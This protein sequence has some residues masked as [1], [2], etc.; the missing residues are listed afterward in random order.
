MKP[1][2]PRFPAVGQVTARANPTATAASTAFPPAR[3]IS[4]PASDARCS[5][6]EI[7]NRG[8]NVARR[9]GWK[10]QDAGKTG[11]WLA[12]GVGSAAPAPPAPPWHDAS[13]RRK[14]QAARNEGRC[15]G[16]EGL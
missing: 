11:V 7:M 10:R 4:L 15:A 8:S 2:P 6:L 5:L 12:G 1:P 14:A 16:I 13:N 9:P 3:M